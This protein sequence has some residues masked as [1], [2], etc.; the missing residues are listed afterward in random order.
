MDYDDDDYFDVP[1]FCRHGLSY[2]HECRECDDVEIDKCLNCG[3]Y[4]ASSSLN[5]DQVC[6]VGCRNPNEY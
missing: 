1:G 2:R 3:K 4:R 6:K 5:A